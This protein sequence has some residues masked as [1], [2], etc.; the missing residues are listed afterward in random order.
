MTPSGTSPDD[1]T[2]PEQEGI[3]EKPRPDADPAPTRAA[4]G[5]ASR[6]TSTSRTPGPAGLLYADVPNRVIALIVDGIALTVVGFVLSLMFG[7][8]VAEGGAIDGSGDG[9]QVG[10]FLVVAVLQAVIS[11]AYFGVG[12][13]TFHGTPGMRMLGLRIG[14]EL[15]GGEIGWRVAVFRWLL[16]G[17]PWILAG[18]AVIVPDAVGLVLSALG[19]AWLLLLLYTMAQSPSKQGLHDR[20]AH[21]IVVRARR[22]ST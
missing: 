8:L 7:G 12:W 2:G 9:L 11:L 20:V 5:L 17:V 15:E 3:W 13:K 6:L 18:F 22:R 14:D 10:P 4:D 1:D 21:T 19:A 16:L